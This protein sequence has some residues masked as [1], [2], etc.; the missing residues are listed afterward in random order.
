M[1][2][3]SQADKPLAK[4]IPQR[5][6]EVYKDEDIDDWDDDFESDS[7]KP[8]DKYWN[9]NKRGAFKAEPPK[10]PS[11]QAAVVSKDVEYEEDWDYDDFE[12]F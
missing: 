5:K 11:V 9:L 8:G 12:D 7:V 2:L 1:Q 10:Q 4:V 6:M 3:S